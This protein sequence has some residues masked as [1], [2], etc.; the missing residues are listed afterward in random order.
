MER[1]KVSNLPQDCLPGLR[2]FQMTEL[3]GFHRGDGGLDR[4]CRRG[5]A[6]EF[7]GGEFEDG[8]AP[9]SEVLLVSDVLVGSDEQFKLGLRQAH[10][11]TVFDAAPAALLC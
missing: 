1:I 5:Q 4:G 11:V 10:Q 6:A 2:Y 7:V 9:A 3:T 8:D